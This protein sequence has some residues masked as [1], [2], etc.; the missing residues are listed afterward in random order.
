MEP[1]HSSASAGGS[2]KAGA[3]H[4]K[5]RSNGGGGDGGPLERGA[6]PP[7]KRSRNETSPHPSSTSAEKGASRAD[8]S[9]AHPKRGGRYQPHSGHGS[10]RHPASSTTTLASSPSSSSSVFRLRAADRHSFPPSRDSSKSPSVFQEGHP[11]PA[12]PHSAAASRLHHHPFRANFNDHFETSTAAL[13]DVLPFVKELRQL[14]RPSTPERF[15]VYDPYYCAGGI[16]KAWNEL[17]VQH[18]LHENRDFY[19]DIAQG[20]LPGPYD[21]LVTNPPFSEDH[22]WRLLDFLVTQRPLKPWAFV[23]PDYI[24]AKPQYKMW[25]Q[26]YF[27]PTATVPSPG[28]AGAVKGAVRRPPP[29]IPS[30]ASILPPFLLPAEAEAEVTAAT[31]AAD[32]EGEKGAPAPPPTTTAAAAAE[33]APAAGAPPTAAVAVP[34]GPEPLY[35][36][37][38]VRYDY[39]HPLGVG[40]DHSHFKSMWYVWAGRH[41]SEVLRGITVEIAARGRHATSSWT[42]SSSSSRSATTATVAGAEQNAPVTV[43]NGY[44]ALIEGHCVAATDRRLNPERRRRGGAVPSRG[45]HG[46]SQGRGGHRGGDSKRVL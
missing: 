15:T 13:R 31:D 6:M 41:T 2:E 23:A 28:P 46:P 8:R 42:S 5:R 18:V 35:I 32:R 21:V 7:T 45:G 30:I 29:S 26:T 33:A 3:Q 10:Q 37:P 36:I 40:H 11:A 16:V 12:A 38:R 20:T 27:T 44:Q 17:G 39:A 25:V 14:L 1:S 19:A 43:V 24:A 4:R 22:I 9:G 34:V